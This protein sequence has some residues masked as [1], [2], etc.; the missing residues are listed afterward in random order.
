MYRK[1]WVKRGYPSHRASAI[2]APPPPRGFAR[3]YHLSRADHAI[4][5]IKKGRLKAATFSDSNDPFELSVFFAQKP[6]QEKRL[7]RFIEETS[8]TYGMV[9]FSEDWLDPVLWSHYADK[10]RGIALG[11]DV[12]KT[13]LLKVKYKR[14]RALTPANPKGNDVSRFLGTKFESWSYEREHRIMV[15]LRKAEVDKGLKFEKFGPE[16]ILREVI[17]GPLCDLELNAVRSEVDSRHANVR[18]FKARLAQTLF[19]VVPDE[20]TIPF[21]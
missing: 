17:L 4:D 19:S 10:H 1:D 14:R 11:F 3:V 2:A 6:D 13:H 9:C 8:R 7:Q 16:V 18:T 20:P 12:K 15:D 5:N 21:R